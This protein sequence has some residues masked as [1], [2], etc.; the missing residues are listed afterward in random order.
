MGRCF[1][2]MPYGSTED[3]RREFSRIYRFLIRT[4]AEDLGLDCVRSDFE[5]RGGHIL[6][7]VIEDLADSDIVVAD[8]TNL[9]WNVAY[10]LGMRHVIHKRGSVLICN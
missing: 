10:E 2:A 7:N 3:E 8:L 4:A 6:N 9:N 5:D 1:V